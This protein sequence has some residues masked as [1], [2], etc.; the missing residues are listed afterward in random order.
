SRDATRLDLFIAGGDG[1][2]YTGAWDANFDLA[3]WRGWWKILTGAIPAGGTIT[4]VSRD[5]NKLDVFLVSTDGGVYTAA[6]D[7]NVANG[8]WRGWWR[9]G[10]LSAKP[11]ATVAAVA[12]SAHQL[13]IFVAGSDGKTYTAAWD[14][15]VDSGK[16]RG[17]WNILT[18][19]IPA[20]GTITAVARD[21]NKLDVFLV[22][23]DGGVYTA[24]W[25]QNVDSGKW[26]GWWRVGTLASVPGAPVA[27]V[28]RSAHQLDIFVAGSDG[29]TYTAAWDQNVSN[30][31]WR[32]W[33]NILTGHIAPGGAISAVSR[34][35]NKLD[36][37]I[38]STDG[39]IY[40]A[41]WDQHVANGQWRGWWRIGV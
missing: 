26:R 30:A 34:D 33:W 37:F 28:A 10:N 2:T 22:S 25:D 12:R 1:K 5:A 7:Q 39:A 27:A 38:C 35:P 23:D 36:I 11:G 13:D 15:N 8:A 9:I 31:Q 17:W 21:P 41:A 14:Q 6:W 29:K 18:G 16:W 32:G 20:S 3:R 40:T 24:A 4:A 19:A